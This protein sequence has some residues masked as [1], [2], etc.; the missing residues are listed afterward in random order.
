M[1]ENG[2]Y[3]SQ[4]EQ[5]EIIAPRINIYENIPE[6]YWMNEMANGVTPSTNLS[7]TGTKLGYKVLS[8]NAKHSSK[9]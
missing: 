9:Y 4:G 6:N 1:D 3:N 5:W 8:P 2:W 7:N